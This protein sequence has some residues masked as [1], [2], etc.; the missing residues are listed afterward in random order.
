MSEESKDPKTILQEAIRKRDE[1]NTFIKVFQQMAGVSEPDSQSAA[2]GDP[3]AGATNTL[4]ANFDPLALV[5]PGMFFGQSQPQA[6][7]MFLERCKPRPQKTKTIVD[8][9]GKGGSPVGG[10]NPAVNLWGILNRNP[11]IFVLV[12]KAGWGLAEWYNAAVIAKMR[13]GGSKDEE[14]AKEEAKEGD[15]KEDKVKE[16]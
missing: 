12:P 1:L 15:A 14:E 16:G 3:K 6:A 10:K 5:F 7:R 9:L 4:D 13:Q 11:D 2:P 8:A